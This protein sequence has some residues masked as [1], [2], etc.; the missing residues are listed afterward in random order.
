M[1]VHEQ[2]TEQYAAIAFE[3]IIRNRL[4]GRTIA[5]LA[6]LSPDNPVPYRAGGHWFG[7][8]GASPAWHRL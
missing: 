2:F 6:G 5:V 3:E 1:Y 4:G 7:S 8:G